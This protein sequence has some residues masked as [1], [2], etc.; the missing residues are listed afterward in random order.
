MTS[1]EL[2]EKLQ[3]YLSYLAQDKNNVNLLLS[4]SDCYRL[5]R[6]WGSAQR[7]LD[8]AQQIAGQPFLTHQ[9]FLHMDSNQMQLAEEAFTQAL[10]HNETPVNRYNLSFC[11]YQNQN[12]E[13]AL[14]VVSSSE[15]NE[16]LPMS[17]LL[18]AKLLHHLQRINEAITVLTQLLTHHDSNAEAAGLLALLYVD[19]NNEELAR[20]LSNKALAINPDNYDGQLVRVLLKTLNDEVT[21]TEIESLLAIKPKD[22]RLLFALGTTQMRYMN[23]PAAEQAFLQTTQIWPFFYE[24][25]ISYG[26]C[27]LLQNNLDKA[28]R[29]YRQA[30]SIDANSA[31]GWGGLAL[32]SALR[33][34]L[35]QAKKWLEKAYEL[36]STCFLAAITRIILANH[37]DPEQAAKWLHTTLPG[38]SA[39][40]SKI[41]SRAIRTLKVEEKV[42]H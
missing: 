35:T 2:H 4:A 3:R 18:K 24:N 26:W 22:G 23:F 1:L 10:T 41:I 36:D 33:L 31:D 11:L 17:A 27:H 16:T 40:I 13:E 7:Y 32:V 6:D 39:E 34:H 29:A 30:V 5:L 37:S 42:V 28:E 12:F 9:G 20:L 21:L 38:V 8:E 19:T 25:W 14:L 15:N